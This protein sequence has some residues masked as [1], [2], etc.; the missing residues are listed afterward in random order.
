M[1][2][3]PFH[4]I[5]AHSVTRFLLLISRTIWFS[6]IINLKFSTLINVAAQNDNE[7]HETA[8]DV[9]SWTCCTALLSYLMMMMIIK[10][11]YWLSPIL[12]IHDWGPSVTIYHI[13][14]CMMFSYLLVLSH[15]FKLPRVVV[16]T[17]TKPNFPLVVNKIHLFWIWLFTSFCDLIS[18]WNKAIQRQEHIS[19]F[20][21]FTDQSNQWTVTDELLQPE[22]LKWCY[23]QPFHHTT[24]V[25]VK[26]AEKFLI[27]YNKTYSYH[28]N[29]LNTV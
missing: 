3:F 27:F 12:G 13:R 8:N 4:S 2:I 10:W 20:L 29:K 25:C 9:T 6:N 23:F 21:S 16:P 24:S 14:K 28:I 26:P 18:L 1:D 7:L 15:I 19:F 22:L 11:S 5:K 17:K